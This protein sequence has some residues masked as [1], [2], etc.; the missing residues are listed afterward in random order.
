MED[1]AKLT[2]VRR[3]RVLIA[4]DAQRSSEKKPHLVTAWAPAF[5]RVHAMVFWTDAG[6]FGDGTRFV[7][8]TDDIRGPTI[9]HTIPYHSPP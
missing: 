7:P 9:D 1:Y 6:P 8:T 2:R 3:R 4:A 5:A